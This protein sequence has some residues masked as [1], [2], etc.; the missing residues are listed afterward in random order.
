MNM[1]LKIEGIDGSSTVDGFA[2]YMEVGSFSFS[3]SQPTSPVRSAADQTTGVPSLSMFSFNKS[4]DKA[5]PLLCQKLWNGVVLAKAQF[6]LCRAPN[7]DEKGPIAYMEIN[8]EN[9]I[10]ANYSISGNGNGVPYEN[11]SLNYAKINF[12]HTTQVTKGEQSG[13]V[14]STYDRV[15]NKSA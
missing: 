6:R 12:K 11:V 4:F 9:V 8:M 14:E 10:V 7:A 5:S 13:S 2:D 1:F 3:S 15:T